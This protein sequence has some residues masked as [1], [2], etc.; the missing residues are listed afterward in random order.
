MP[1]YDYQCKFCKLQKEILTKN[2]TDELMYCHACKRKSLVKIISKSSFILKGTGWYQT[3]F[4][5][6]NSNKKNI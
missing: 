4:K 3:D 1:I 6:K 2:I 5:K